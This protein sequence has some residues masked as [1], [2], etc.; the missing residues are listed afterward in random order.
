MRKFFS[1]SFSSFFFFLIRIL[2]QRVGCFFLPP[3]FLLFDAN[4]HSVNINF[5]RDLTI[6]FR[7]L[8]SSFEIR[9]FDFIQVA[10][11]LVTIFDILYIWTQS[12][13]IVILSFWYPVSKPFVYITSNMVGQNSELKGALQ[14]NGRMNDDKKV[15]EMLSTE[16]RSNEYSRSSEKKISS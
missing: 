9:V 13:C 16:N 14:K 6:I 10:L 2:S 11:V 15:F 8:F 12:G 7:A 3:S 4:R 1:S 5:S